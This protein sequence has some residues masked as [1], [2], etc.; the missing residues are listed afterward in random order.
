MSGVAARLNQVPTSLR[1]K[2]KFVVSQSQ[3]F[4]AAI[5]GQFP[6]CTILSFDDRGLFVGETPIS[7]AVVPEK[8]V[9]S[10]D[11]SVVC[12]GEYSLHG[13]RS[14][15]VRIYA[16]PSYACKIIDLSTACIPND[17]FGPMRSIFLSEWNAEDLEFVFF[18]SSSELSIHSK[19]HRGLRVDLTRATVKR[20]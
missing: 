15:I 18:G 16:H 2:P 1:A 9:I 8:S 12:F 19:G 17:A 5:G 10:D 20:E 7:L 13:E 6:S 4:A 3:Q 11:G 14:S